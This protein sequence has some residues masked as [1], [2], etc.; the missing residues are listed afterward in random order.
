MRLSP[1]DLEKLALRRDKLAERLA[2]LRSALDGGNL[3]VR[4]FISDAFG[5]YSMERMD[6][7]LTMRLWRVCQ[8][9]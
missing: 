2:R 8:A 3:P 9:R 7:L 1:R 5:A 4:P 6:G